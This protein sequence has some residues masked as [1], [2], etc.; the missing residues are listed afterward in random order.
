MGSA[1]TLTKR[2][3]MATGQSGHQNFLPVGQSQ[4]PQLHVLLWSI[5]G[6]V[7]IPQGREFLR[8]LLCALRSFLYVLG[9]CMTYLAPIS[10]VTQA[11]AHE[12]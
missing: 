1:V 9:R 12:K 10:M 6:L 8:D 7:R 11:C 4:R 5:L 3:V 2:R